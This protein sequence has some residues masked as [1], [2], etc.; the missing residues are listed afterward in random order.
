MSTCTNVIILMQ[1]LY[2][3]C[4]LLNKISLFLYFQVLKE[5]MM[6]CEGDEEWIFDRSAELGILILR[7]FQY[8]VAKKKI[9]ATDAAT[10]GEIIIVISA[11]TVIHYL[12]LIFFDTIIYLFE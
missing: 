11:F 6:M 8:A 9:N 7:I 10:I 12:K 3:V 2:H 5:M 1:Y 4:F